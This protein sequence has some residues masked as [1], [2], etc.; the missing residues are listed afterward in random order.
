MYADDGLEEDEEVEEAVGEY[1]VGSVRVVS[2]A[3]KMDKAHRKYKYPSWQ[4]WCSVRM[5]RV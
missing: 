4:E 5:E 2:R 1:S 3:E